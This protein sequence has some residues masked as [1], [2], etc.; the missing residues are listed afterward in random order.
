MGF[1]TV[2]DIN[3]L[4]S[5][6]KFEANVFHVASAVHSTAQTSRWDVSKKESVYVVN[7]TTLLVTGDLYVQYHLQRNGRS[8]VE[9]R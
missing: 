2:I 3:E 6:R 1:T 7:K 4:S 8:T 9:P 5:I